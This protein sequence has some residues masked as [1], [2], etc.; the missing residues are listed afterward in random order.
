MHT[1]EEAASLLKVKQSWLERQAA[2]RKIPFAI[3]GGSYRF[4]DRHIA[5]IVRINEVAP[6]RAGRN[7][8]RAARTPRIA[9]DGAVLA[10]ASTPL[11]PR[12]RNAP[13]HA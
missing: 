12:P 3:L 9:P 13:R 5:E 11:R 6:D 10:G 1:A 8:P 2:S 4:S 7:A